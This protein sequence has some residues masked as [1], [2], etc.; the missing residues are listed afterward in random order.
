MSKVYVVI[1]NP[2]GCSDLSILGV[3]STR[4]LAD[5]LVDSLDPEEYD[6]G[7]VANDVGVTEV[8]LDEG[9]TV[10]IW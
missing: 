6:D 9:K 3:Y 7:V 5:A 8:T 1:Y 2:I 10:Y 4:P